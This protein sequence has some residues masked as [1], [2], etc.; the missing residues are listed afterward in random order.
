[1]FNLQCAACDTKNSCNVNWTVISIFGHVFYLH[2][3]KFDKQYD[4]ILNN[5]S[6]QGTRHKKKL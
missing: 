2:D 4:L 1:M 6:S 5:V 3:Q